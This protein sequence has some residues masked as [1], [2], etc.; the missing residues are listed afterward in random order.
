[1][2]KTLF[3][4]QTPEKRIAPPQVGDND[5]KYQLRLDVGKAVHGQKNVYLQVDSR[6]KDDALKDFRGKNGSCAKLATATVHP[7]HRRANRFQH[8]ED[9]SR[10]CVKDRSGAKDITAAAHRHCGDNIWLETLPTCLILS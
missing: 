9:H 2:F 10:S 1:M 8:F 7:K 6:A 3:A 5:A 4:K